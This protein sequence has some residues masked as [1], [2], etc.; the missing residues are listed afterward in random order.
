MTREEEARKYFDKGN[1]QFNLGNYEQAIADYTKAI[2]IKPGYA[3]AYYNRGNAKINL[4]RH[5]E[6]IEDY[7]T[8]I[9]SRDNFAEAYNNRGI[10]KNHLGRYEEAIVDYTE[11]IGSGDN[12]AEAYNNRGNAKS[13]LGRHEEAIE[14]CTK[15]IKIKPGYA[16]AY[17]NRGIA[18]S[19]LGRHEEAIED[20]TKA[21]EIEPDDAGA[22]Y[23]R[24]KIY[25]ELKKFDAAKDDFYSLI[26]TQKENSKEKADE[27]IY[28]Y[29]PINKE[30]LSSLM[31]QE[32]YFA[33]YAKLNDPFECYF[34]KKSW[35]NEHLKRKNKT[36]RILALT[37]NC[38]SPPMYSHYAQKHTGICVG[39]KIDFDEIKANDNLSY[40]DVQY[41]TKNKIENLKDLYMLKSPEWSYE[42]EYR[43]VRFDN[44]KFINN[45][46]I[47]EIIFALHCT[48]K[49]KKLVY[50]LTNKYKP[51]YRQAKANKDSN[52]LDIKDLTED[53]IKELKAK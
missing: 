31:H 36:A 17:N 20:Y 21:I 9:G 14:D 48:D 33:D 15:A 37:Y 47:K 46:A 52:L 27:C 16:E 25:T 45:I 18:K 42:K 29:M 50:A 30:K 5:E 10:A 41:A 23:N 13:G 22:Y 38:N 26:S 6:A 53:A 4:G 28:Q 19:G 51:T 49:D 24:G 32:L 39:Y 35:V 1:E 44:E 34:M 3:G 7:T 2:K 11:A 8:A 43:L 40:G 12:Y